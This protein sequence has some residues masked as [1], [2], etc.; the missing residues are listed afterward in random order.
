MLNHQHSMQPDGNVVGEPSGQPI[1]TISMSTL[2]PMVCLALP[3]KARNAWAHQAAISA[4]NPT[5]DP[6]SAPSAAI[7]YE[8]KL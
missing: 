5:A 2:I 6:N 4:A 1:I 8:M 7:R 3:G